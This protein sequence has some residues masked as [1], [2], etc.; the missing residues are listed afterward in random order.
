MPYTPAERTMRAQLGAHAQWARTEDRTAR[1]QAAR[2][3]FYA[4]FERQVDPEG[5]L[6]PEERQ[7]RAAHLRKAYMLRLSLA[8]ARAR[9]RNAPECPAP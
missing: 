9:R 8:S 7:R 6:P 5:L 3:G 1:T 4:R 2:D